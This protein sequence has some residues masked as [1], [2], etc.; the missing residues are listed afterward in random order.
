MPEMS[1]ELPFSDGTDLFQRLWCPNWHAAL[2]YG[3]HPMVVWRSA[4]QVGQRL[5]AP[6][7]ARFEG[8]DHDLSEHYYLPLPCVLH[9]ERAVEYPH[10]EQPGFSDLPGALDEQVRRWQQQQ[11]DWLCLAELS[12]APGTKVGGYPRW[13]Q[14]RSGRCAT[15]GGAW[16]TCPPS[17][18]KSSNPRTLAAAGGPGR[19]PDHHTAAPH[20]PG[21]LGAARHHAR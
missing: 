17:P 4:A 18:A 16:T 20:G 2:W 11:R 14:P 13:I 1:P 7:A 12:T 15:A 9:P 19:S 3:P 5:A 21:R 6:P 10:A 8:L